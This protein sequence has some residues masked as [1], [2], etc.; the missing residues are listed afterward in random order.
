MLEITVHPHNGLSLPG[1]GHLAAGKHSVALTADDLEGAEG[2]TIGSA[3]SALARP[4]E[5]AAL[6]LEIREA[7]PQLD[8][9]DTSLW[10]TSGKAKTEALE[11]VLGYKITAAERD[12]AL[13]ALAEV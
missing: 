3:G 5:I 2:I 13:A 8:T 11:A 1:I 4:E 6:S 7:L 10:T 9:D 12:A